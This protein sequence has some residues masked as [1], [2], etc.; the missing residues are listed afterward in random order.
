MNGSA[1]GNKITSLPVRD[2]GG[3]G[4]SGMLIVV[5]V[6]FRLP[7]KK[8]K[9]TP[10]KPTVDTSGL[11]EK[12]SKIYALICRGDVTTATEISTLTGIP[13]KT[14]RRIVT[15]LVEKGYVERIGGDRYGKWIPVSKSK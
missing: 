2:G 10:I 6:I 8:D 4:G 1:S 9:N 5:E 13:L 3:G 12:E 7:E 14:T 11:T 15:G